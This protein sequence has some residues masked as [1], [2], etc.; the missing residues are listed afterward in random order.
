M[1]FCPKCRCEYHDE[2]DVCADCQVKLVPTL[3]EEEYPSDVPDYKDWVHMAR[4][5]SQPSADMV[6]EGLRSKNIPVVVVSGAGHFGLLGQMGP[7]S[8]RPV[9]GGYSVMIPKDYVAQADHEAGL[10]LGDEWE[11]A[12]LLD[13]DD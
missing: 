8:F 9:G 11:K 10:I 12:K 2:I 4:L 3:P 7:S 1:P 6:V 13:I 5:T